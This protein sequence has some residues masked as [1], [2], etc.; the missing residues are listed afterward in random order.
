MPFQQQVTISEKQTMAGELNLRA[1][2]E[3]ITTV[4]CG[5]C[6]EPGIVDQNFLTRKT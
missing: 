5:R 4:I 2:L 6:C 1:L 3:V